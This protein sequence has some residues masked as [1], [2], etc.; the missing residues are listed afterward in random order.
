[1]RSGSIVR[2]SHLAR[3][4]MRHKELVGPNTSRTLCLHQP[5][6]KYS[7]TTMMILRN[8]NSGKERKTEKQQSREKVRNN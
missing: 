1:M 8:K 5:L 6:P 2:N 3:A 4:D 7:I